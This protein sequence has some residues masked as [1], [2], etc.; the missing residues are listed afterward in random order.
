MP[1][2]VWASSWPQRGFHYPISRFDGHFSLPEQVSRSMKRSPFN[3]TDILKAKFLE[4][5]N[6]F[7]IKCSAK[8]LGVIDAH[9]PNPGRLWELLIPGANLYL[10]SDVGSETDRRVKRKTSYTALAAERKGA[11]IFL[12]TH[13]TNQVAR[14]LIESKSVPSLNKVEIV[15]QEVAL[16]RSRFDFLLRENGS[17]LYL[18][19]KSC[20]LFGNGVAM[21]PDAVTE[22]G[23]R[24]LFELAQM[25]RNGINAMILFVVHYPHVDWFM[26]DFHTDYD[27]SES[28]L[29]AKDDLRILPV[30]IAWK[31]DL[32][33]GQNVKVLQTPWEYLREEVHDRGSYL[34]VVRLDHEKHL[35]IGQLGSIP[36]QK[37]YY[38]Y[39]G[40]AMANLTAR[41]K[42]HKRIRKKDHW[43]IDYLRQASDEVLSLPIRSSR[44]EECE[45]AASL[46]S[47]FT[48]APSGFGS[49]DC[50]C[51]T[52]LFWSR[53]NPL[54]V[55]AFHDV[56]QHFRMRHP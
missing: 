36:F 23:R 25:G 19:V 1:Q 45:I 27:F 43:H 6:R 51:R 55:E 22:R 21:F 13:L 47:A 42:R 53:E 7:L 14:Y 31:P 34:L 50:Q 26:P 5:P 56:L 33:I 32:T 17:D 44:R 48:S 52:H 39:V 9:L 4:R 20:T 8:G 35:H 28:L 46:S 41:I 54:H 3:F 12:H 38:V 11:P 24:H 49:S 16:G 18:E 30:A 37:G 10:S 29:K 40:S 15:K 2:S